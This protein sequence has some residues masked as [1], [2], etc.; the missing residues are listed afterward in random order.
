MLRYKASGIAKYGQP[1]V[2]E[3]ACDCGLCKHD[4]IKQNKNKIKICTYTS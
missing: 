2:K 4:V 1:L 3:I